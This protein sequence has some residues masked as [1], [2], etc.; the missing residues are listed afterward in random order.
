MRYNKKKTPGKLRRA[1]AVLSAAII[2]TSAIIAFTGYA[3][4]SEETSSKPLP[5]RLNDT[6]SNSMSDLVEFASMDRKV[7]EWIRFWD[8]KGVSLA[9]MRNDSL[10][11]A[12]GYGWADVEEGIPMET[13]SK[14]RIASVSKLITAT[15]VMKLNEQ[16]KMPLDTLVFGSEGILN[17]SLYLNAADKRI[18]DITVEHL[19][20]HQGGFTLSRGDP[21]FCTSDIMRWE[22]LTVPPTQERLVEYILSRHLGYKPGTWQKY[23]NVGYMFLSLAIQK[24][25]GIDYERYIRDSILIPAGCYDMHLG[26]TYYKDRYPDEVRY[27]MHKDAVPVEDFH[28]DGSMVDKC[29]GGSDFERLMGA[30]GWITSAP[31][32]ARFIASIDGKDQVPD[33]ISKESVMKMTE[34]IDNSTFPLGWADIKSNGEWYRSGTLSGTSVL[35]KYFPDGYCWILITNSSTWKGSAFSRDI[36]RLFN[37]LDRRVKTWPARDLFNPAPALASDSTTIVKC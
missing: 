10:L 2:C 6:L 15:A 24:V 34:Y 1:V 32:L 37:D 12:K 19:L 11:F 35:V 26:R 27:Y 20:R 33:I 23:S 9:V 13:F 5:A 36:S 30:G 22:R 31:E 4:C 18:Y 7:R 16:G 14:L 29:Y 28:L 25:T 3:S 8:I 17:D 21:M